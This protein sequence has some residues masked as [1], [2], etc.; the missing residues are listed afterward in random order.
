M[1]VSRDDGDGLPGSIP[2]ESIP[3]DDTVEPIGMADLGRSQ[4]AHTS[5]GLGSGT[6]GR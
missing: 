1:I 2:G 3:Q 4:T 6:Q 5:G